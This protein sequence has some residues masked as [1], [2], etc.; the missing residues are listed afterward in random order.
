MCV[1]V[2]VDSSSPQVQ[3]K[4]SGSGEDW[5]GKR[6]EDSVSTASSLHSSPTVSPQGSPRKGWCYITDLK[7]QMAHS[8]PEQV[9]TLDRSSIT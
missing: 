2:C 6:P 5:S 3:K 7:K 8:F 4:A 9:C 1:Y